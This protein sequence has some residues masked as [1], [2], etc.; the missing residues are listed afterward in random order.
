MDLY[1][2]VGFVIFVIANILNLIL[3]FKVWGMT[4]DVRHFLKFYI[5]DKGITL[6]EVENYE[7]SG[8]SLKQ[9]KNKDGKIID[10]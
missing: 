8:V 1:I 2:K 4:N 5:D 6:T 3:F 10:S 9:Y 7:N